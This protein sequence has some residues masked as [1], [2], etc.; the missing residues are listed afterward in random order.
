MFEP[1][2]I[3]NYFIKNHSNDDN[4]TPM[5]V[6]KLVYIAYGW[7]LALTDGKRLVNEKPEAW[8]LGPVFPSLYHSLKKYGSLKI[9]DPIPLNGIGYGTKIK[10]D[11]IKKFLDIIWEAYGEHNAIYLSSITHTEDTP[12]SQ[13]FPSGFNVTIPDDLILDHYKDKLESNQREQATVNV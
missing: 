10:D 1:S 3:A 6:I 5:K 8:N 9:K 12:W 4:L 7:Y 13:V 2:A 11:S